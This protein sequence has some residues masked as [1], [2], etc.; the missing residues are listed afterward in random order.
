MRKKVTMMIVLMALLTGCGN[1]ADTAVPVQ[2]VATLSGITDDIVRLSYAG[3]VST[4]NEVNVRRVSGRKIAKVYVRKGDIVKAGDKLFTYD[5]EQAQNN[6]DKAMMELEEKKNTLISR[7]QERSQLET[8]MMK[9]QQEDQLE[10]SL[11][12]REIDTDIRELQYNIDHIE[13]DILKLEEGTQDLDVTAPISGRVEKAGQAD[14][15][16][17]EYSS[18]DADEQTDEDDIALDDEGQGSEAFIKLVEVDNYRIKGRIDESNISQITTG[19]KMVIHS[20][21]SDEVWNGVVSDIDLSSM[22][23]NSSDDVDDDTDTENASGYYFYVQIEKLDGLI[24]GQHVYMT[25]DTGEESDTR[26]RISSSFIIDA[27]QSPWVWAEKGGVLEKRD[28]KL[29]EYLEDEGAYV[30]EDGLDADDFIAV[31]S[32]SCAAGKPVKEDVSEVFG[33]SDDGVG[34]NDAD[35][36]SL[37]TDDVDEEEDLDTD[38]ADEDVVG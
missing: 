7:Q 31:P 1:K 29:G 28:V 5:A 23:K 25:A 37:D 18:G 19:M 34:E 3:I 13:K 9:V 16:F 15:S 26:I 27:E 33:L 14:T 10:Y 35:E 12:I 17:T 11:K 30:I 4:G 24:I 32:D 22:G 38:D 2:S 36:E 21:V 20:R 6:L 8:D